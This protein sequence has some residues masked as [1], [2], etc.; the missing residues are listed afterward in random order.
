MHEVLEPVHQRRRFWFVEPSKVGTQHITLIDGYL[1]ALADSTVVQKD[2]NVVLCCHPSVH[3]ELSNEVRSS[4]T[5]E[6]TV[7]ID[8][9]ARR[10]VPKILLEVWVV[11][12]AMRRA[13]PGDIVFISCVLSTALWMIEGMNRLLKRRNVYVVLHGEVEGL[14][15]SSLRGFKNFGYW[16]LRWIRLRRPSS[17]LN[18]VVIDDFIRE[19][20][21]A[22]F[23]QQIKPE[24]IFTI[25]HPVTALKFE[26]RYHSAQLK[27]CF[28]GYRTKFKGY[29]EFESLAR[30]VP[31]L[32]FVAIGGGKV[33][34]VPSGETQPLAENGG[35]LGAVADCAVAI[36]PY[37]GGYTASL[38]AAALDALSAGVHIIAT[39]RPCFVGLAETFGPETVTIC[40]D[41][42]QISALLS[43]NTWVERQCELQS[44]RL[45][46]LKTSRYSRDGVRD[47]FDR[48]V[49][50]T[51]ARASTTPATFDS[52]A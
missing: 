28:I 35:Y 3:A 29:Q 9:E 39:D 43:D 32:E 11:F 36:F 42:R 23:P 16:S 20:L 4:I 13:R 24:R 33:E 44:V 5:H 21:L 25:H 26:Q 12:Q 6:S 50:V 46:R 7:V 47:G 40:P 31:D 17:L 1:R 8:P 49:T 22:D 41:I 27:V 30:A 52:T 37:V 14:Y 48:L 45:A 38:S 19:R 18:L 34:R 2:F 51:L 10:F 15:D